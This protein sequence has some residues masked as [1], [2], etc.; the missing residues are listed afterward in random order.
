MLNQTSPMQCLEELIFTPTVK[1]VLVRYLDGMMSVLSFHRGIHQ[2][3]T[4]SAAKHA[5]IMATWQR[6]P[7]QKSR[8]PCVEQIY[9]I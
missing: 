8:R 5:Q 1:D 3:L 4:R 7:G 6:V 2:N 9:P